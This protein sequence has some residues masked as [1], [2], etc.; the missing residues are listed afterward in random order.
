VSVIQY[1]DDIKGYNINVFKVGILIHR[2]DL[3]I[4]LWYDDRVMP[5]ESEISRS[6]SIA[7]GGEIRKGGFFLHVRPALTTVWLGEGSVLAVKSHKQDV[8]VKLAH[9]VRANTDYASA[10]IG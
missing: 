7:L 6:T 5:R 2:M 4:S 10:A 1:L 9:P 3:I 8:S